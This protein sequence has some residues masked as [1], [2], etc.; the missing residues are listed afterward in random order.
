MNYRYSLKWLFLLIV[1][2]VVMVPFIPEMPGIGLDPSWMMGVNQIV[3]QDFIFGKEFIFTYGPYGSILTKVYHPATDGLMLYGSLYLVIGLSLVAIQA[4]KD[5]SWMWHITFGVCFV[6]ILSASHDSLFFIY[7]LI[8]IIATD[9]FGHALSQ[10]T[11]PSKIDYVKAI[12]YFS[13]LGFLPLIKGT[14]ILICG[15]TAVLCACF[16]YKKQ[17]S[18]LSLIAILTTAV[19]LCF[20][21]LLSGQSLVYVFHY[22]FASLQIISG[23]T[24]AMSAKG[25]PRE[26]VYYLIASSVILFCLYSSN[27]HKT[28]EARLLTLGTLL[29]LFLTFKSSFVRHD[30]PHAVAAS[31]AIL[32]TLFF[33]WHNINKQYLAI[34][35][36]VALISWSYI[37][38][39]HKQTS[40]KDF[41]DKIELSFSHTFAGIKERARS[42][43]PLS[44]SYDNAMQQIKQQR[45]L[46]KITG[47]SDVYSHGQTE[48]LAHDYEWS[49]RPVF[50]SYSVYSPELLEKNKQHLLS[51][52]APDNILF[53]IEPI[54]N[55]FPAIEDGLSWGVILS[56]Y[57]PI[58][59][60][61][62]YVYLKKQ[63]SVNKESMYTILTEE[64][65]KMGEFIVLP[66]TDNVV[67]A[68]I[69]IKSTLLGKLAN[70]L[71]KPSR[72]YVTVNLVDGT[73]KKFRLIRR[74]IQTEFLLSPLIENKEE[75]LSLYNNRA[76]LNTKKIVS[77]SISDEKKSSLFWQKEITIT[78]K[79]TATAKY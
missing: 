52:Q 23:Y 31:T 26:I 60:D 55:R 24:E 32:F 25:N 19:S 57:T 11:A 37:D 17:Q 67:F 3:A 27:K 28:A 50:Q 21:W 45:P 64:T 5:A 10:K 74:M 34:C 12:V 40:T 8:L 69:E 58:D 44:Q 38:R 61:T 14:L 78:Y 33:H 1:F 56:N 29:F 59:Q 76:S 51:N 53:N 39:K 49:P 72:L 36:L 73:T 68:S 16:F 18:R 62:N 2:S 42:G 20:F 75:F 66:N 30:G 71:L 7:C 13:P 6:A 41:F 65:K 47:T 9:H 35:T 4:F 77:F 79:N 15:A 22:F 46:K 63:S 70:F 48:L 54:D 43:N